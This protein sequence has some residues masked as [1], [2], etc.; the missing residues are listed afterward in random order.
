MEGGLIARMVC[1]SGDWPG[2]R[3]KLRLSALYLMFKGNGS[4]REGQDG[5][6]V[7]RASE[8]FLIGF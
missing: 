3:L 4:V 7:F 6:C 5:E 1:G 8:T 2:I